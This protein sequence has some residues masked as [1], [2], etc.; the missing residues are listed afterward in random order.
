[1]FYCLGYV[2]NDEATEVVVVKKLKP[3]FQKGKLNGIGGKVED[4]ETSIFAMEREFQEE[5]GYKGLINWI[6]GLNIISAPDAGCPTQFMM[7]VFFARDQQAHDF[8]TSPDYVRPEA[9]E[10]LTMPIP[11]VGG[12]NIQNPVMNNVYWH[13]EMFRYFLTRYDDMPQLPICLSYHA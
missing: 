9:E 8:V 5:T 10:I 4:G 13:V 7:D 11:S 6:H 3:A 2:L 12:S 1:M